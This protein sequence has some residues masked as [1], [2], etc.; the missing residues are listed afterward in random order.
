MIRYAARYQDLVEARLAILSDRPFDRGV[1]LQAL[2][3][4]ICRREENQKEKT[5]SAH[6]IR[7]R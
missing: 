1:V 4:A 7:G 6:G 2:E 5:W 3:E